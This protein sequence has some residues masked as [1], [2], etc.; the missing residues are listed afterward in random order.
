MPH[1]RRRSSAYSHSNNQRKNS[2]SQHQRRTN[3][4]IDISRRRASSI[5]FHINL[6]ETEDRGYSTRTIVPKPEQRHRNISP[7]RQFHGRGETKERLHAYCISHDS[8]YA[9]LSARLD[10]FRRHES[11]LTTLIVRT[12]GFEE[13]GAAVSLLRDVSEASWELERNLHEM[14]EVVV[15]NMKAEQESRGEGRMMLVGGRWARVIV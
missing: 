12:K 6:H 3:I 13:G 10:R 11:I 15:R 14:R 8:T 4:G 5:R 1:H 2:H 7:N 9:R